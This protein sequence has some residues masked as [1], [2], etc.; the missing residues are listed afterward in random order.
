MKVEYQEG[1]ARGL[2]VDRINFSL[3]F[4]DILHTV[5]VR[6][7]R[8]GHGT[9]TRDRSRL[10]HRRHCLKRILKETTPWKTRH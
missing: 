2:L 9:D 10:A 4:I 5:F 6:L 8:I 1:N 3:L 7:V